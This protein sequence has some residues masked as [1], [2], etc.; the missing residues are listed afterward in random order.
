MKNSPAGRPRV[1][2]QRYSGQGESAPKVRAKAVIDGKR[3]NIPVPAY[4]V[5]GGRRRLD[6][7]GVGSPGSKMWAENLENPILNAEV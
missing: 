4:I 1:P 6:N 2:V 3:V 7:P 5:M